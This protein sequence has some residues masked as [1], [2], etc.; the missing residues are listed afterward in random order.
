SDNQASGKWTKWYEEGGIESEG[1]Y[2]NG[3]RTGLW[4]IWYKNGKPEEESQ[5]GDGKRDGVLKVWDRKGI[6]IKNEIYFEGE[7]ISKTK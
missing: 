1:E 2:K 7:L 4:R 6:L 5:W 3:V